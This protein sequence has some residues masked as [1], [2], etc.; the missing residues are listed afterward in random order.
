[1]MKLTTLWPYWIVSPHLYLERLKMIGDGLWSHRGYSREFLPGWIFQI[2]RWISFNFDIIKKKAESHSIDCFSLNAF[3]TE[4]DINKIMLSW[5]DIR[6]SILYVISSEKKDDINKL[7]DHGWLVVVLNVQDDIACENLGMICISK[8]EELPLSICRLNRKAVDCSLLVIGYTMKPSREL[9]FAKRGA[10]PL[11]PT[12]N[13]LIFMPLTFELPL[14]SQLP[15]VDVILHKATDEILFVELSNFSD[16]SNK[17]TYSSRMQELQRYIEV[18]SDLCVVDPLN[19]IQP[20]LDRLEIQQIL[21]RLEEALKSEGCMIRGPHFLKVGN[22]NEANLVQNLSEAKLSLPCIV[23]PQVACGVSDAHKMAIIFKVED[24]KNL[25]VPLP[26][27]IQEYVDH[28]STLYKFYVLGEKIFYAVKKSTPNISTLINLNQSDKLG[29]LVF[30][31]L[32]SLPIAD[33]SQQLE[34]KKDKDINLELIQ[35]SANWLRRVL[36]LSIFGF[37]VVVED[38][39]GDHVIVDVNYLPSFKEVPDGIA[40]PAFWEAIKNKYDNFKKATKQ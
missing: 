25:N 9:D 5:G 8:L 21:L 28:S 36:D 2:V 6:N 15:E 18:H 23:K 38:E 39:S 19:N 11:Y 10:F 12:E 1:M 7:I 32:K 26:A 27:I 4:D 30:D 20:V 31:S 35:N 3:L 40:I 34:G 16:L 37:D 13:G 22:F 17:V 24:L 33:G 14:P 29:P